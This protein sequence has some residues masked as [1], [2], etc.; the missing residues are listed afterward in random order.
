VWS[1]SRGI[2]STFT[3]S[4]LIIFPIVFHITPN[5]IWITTSF[6]CM[7]PSMHVHT[8]HWCYK[9]PP[10]MLCPWRWVQS[11]HDVVHDIFVAIAWDA[12]FNVGQEQLHPFFSITFH[13]F[14]QR[15]DV[16]FTKNGICILIDVV[17]A[18]LTWMDLF[19]WSCAT[20]RFIASKVIQTKKR[21]IAINTP[22]IISIWSIWMF[23]QTSW[24]VLTWLCQCHVKLQRARGPSYFCLGYFSP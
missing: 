7:Y 17:I 10:F 22:L 3:T 2:K 16:V 1:G 18:N 5:V 13:S 11:T 23:K 24:C 14:R 9:F 12:N 8:S 15:V 20:R 21:A 4:L 19:C 6:N